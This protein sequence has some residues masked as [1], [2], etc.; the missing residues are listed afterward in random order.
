[1][2]YFCIGFFPAF[3]DVVFLL[4]AVPEE[5]GFVTVGSGVIL[6]KGYESALGVN[7]DEELHN[8]SLLNFA[9]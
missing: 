3:A 1:M 2:F 4:L 8:S 9:E 7:E 6:V 5:E